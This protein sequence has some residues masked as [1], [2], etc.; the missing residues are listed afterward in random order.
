MKY[1]CVKEYI[2][3]E[4]LCDYESYGIKSDDPEYFVTDV[5]CDEDLVKKIV[6]ALNDNEV[7]PVHM[8][9]IIVDMLE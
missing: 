6:Q 2:H 7:E 5:A 3:N 9:D 4:E 1:Y 8:M